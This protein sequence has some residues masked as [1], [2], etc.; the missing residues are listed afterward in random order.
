M[1]KIYCSLAELVRDFHCHHYFYPSERRKSGKCVVFGIADRQG[2]H[3][4]AGKFPSSGTSD[5][6]F[7]PEFW[8]RILG[9][10]LGAEALRRT[11]EQKVST[12]N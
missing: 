5:R 6:N 10:N 4:H 3:Y 7:G 11:I 1:F 2:G 8:A 12:P 9:R